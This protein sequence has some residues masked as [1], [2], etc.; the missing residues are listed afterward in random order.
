MEIDALR[1]ARRLIETH[2]PWC[3]IE[4]WKVGEAPIIATF[5]GLDYTFYRIDGLNMLCA[6]PALGPTEADH[7]GRT[8][9]RHVEGGTRYGAPGSDSRSRRR[10]GA[11]NEL[12]SRTRPRVARRMGPCHRP[13]APCARAAADDDAIALQL[14][15]CYGFAGAPES[16]GARTLRRSCRPARRDAWAHRTRAFGAAAARRPAR[17]AALATI[18]SENVLTA[19]QFGLATER[20]T[21]ASRC[22]ANGCSCSATAA[23]ATSS[24]TRATCLRSA[25]SAARA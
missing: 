1:G 23:S 7:L 3:W 18:A 20:S 21:R 12:E 25:H 9:R 19:A 24:S 14:A 6:E 16:R 10:R 4:Y 5:A 13:L 15:S 8:A 2:L 22:K 11:R 17:R